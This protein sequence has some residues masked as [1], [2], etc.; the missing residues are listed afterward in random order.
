MILTQ[1]TF[2]D[3]V[4]PLQS[5][6]H[7]GNGNGRKLRTAQ[8]GRISTDLNLRKGMLARRHEGLVPAEGE[9]CSKAVGIYS[10]LS[11][12]QKTTR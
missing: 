8:D 7:T 6:V 2:A 1:S 11:S 4:Q 9:M 12:T 5:Q 10:M 3:T